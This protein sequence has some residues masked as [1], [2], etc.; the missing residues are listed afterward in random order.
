MLTNEEFYWLNL[1]TAFAFDWRKTT[2]IFQQAATYWQCHS[3]YFVSLAYSEVWN[4]RTGS[5]VWAERCAG[6]CER[7]CMNFFCAESSILDFWFI[8]SCVWYFIICVCFQCVV[9]SIL[10]HC[11]CS[12]WCMWLHSLP[13]K[14]NNNYIFIISFCSFVVSL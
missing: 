13:N 5:Q 3:A 1:W 14:F 4:I 6:W 10:V 8:L 7:L 2:D 12:L 9:F 11:I